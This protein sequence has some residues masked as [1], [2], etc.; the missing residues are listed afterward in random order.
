MKTLLRSAL[1]KLRRS[2]TADLEARSQ[3][4]LVLLGQLHVQRVRALPFPPPA[5]EPVRERLWPCEF[6]VFS[7]WG[8]DGI[9]QY[10]IHNLPI[11]HRT[12][13]EFG[14]EDYRESNTRFL[15]LHD[16]WQGFVMDGSE[17]HLAA[18]RRDDLFWRHDLQARAAF[19]TRESI[20][21]LLT[22]TG[23]DP[24]VGLLSID[25]D[26]NDYWVWEA[27]TCIRPRLVVCE[28]NGLF[29]LDP[30]SIPYDPAFRRTAAHHSNLYF[31]AS[32]TALGQLAAAR[33][34]VFVGANRAGCNAFF[35]RADLAPAGLGI[36]PAQGYIE[37]L[38][39]QSR[40]ERGALT[41]SRGDER[42]RLIAHLPVVDVIQ[43]QTRP[44]G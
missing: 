39:R 37:G 24:D 8:E 6:K 26:G 32:I 41:F 5:G 29:G 36:A 11:R 12:F 28:Y 34:Y 9:L 42:R 22:G 18:I 10:L 33:G 25:I 19:V 35:V 43:G 27:I 2:M 40:D 14:V 31:G 1:M 7:Q 20:D 30:V 15:L 38:A 21:A 23:F 16:D 17:R 13:I 3:D 4:A 44:L